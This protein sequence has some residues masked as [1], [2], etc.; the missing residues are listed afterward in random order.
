V[1]ETLAVVREEEGEPVR[2]MVKRDDKGAAGDSNERAIPERGIGESQ[3]TTDEESLKEQFK[4]SPVKASRAEAEV[5]VDELPIL[6][7]I[8]REVRIRLR[9]ND[10]RDERMGQGGFQGRETWD[11]TFKVG[12]KV[13]IEQMLQNAQGE[14]D[15]PIE[16][17]FSVKRFF[18]I[19]GTWPSNIKSFKFQNDVIPPLLKRVLEE[20]VK[21]AK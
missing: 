4:I 14:M 10:P 15:E 6:Q 1:Q 9:L 19:M 21:H 11:V 2:K 13:R 5:H 3:A 12:D 20:D 16:H 7:V 8:T 17:E 18:D